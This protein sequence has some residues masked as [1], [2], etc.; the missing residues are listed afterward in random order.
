[1]SSRKASLDDPRE[2][3]IAGFG[4]ATPLRRARAAAPILILASLCVSCGEPCSFTAEREILADGREGLTNLAFAM[5]RRPVRL[6]LY[7]LLEGGSAIIEIDHP[8]GRTT[9]A[10]S[11]EGRG[12][13]EIRKEFDKEPGSWGLRVSARGGGVSYWAALHDRKGYVGP[14]EEARRLVEGRR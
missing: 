10:F 3:G 2:R 5:N 6:E 12:I 7:M 8:D 1:L 14:D 4:R 11:V 9:E 13:R